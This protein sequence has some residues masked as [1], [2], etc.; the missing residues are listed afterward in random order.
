MWIGKSTAVYFLCSM[1]V[2]RTDSRGQYI[3][4]NSKTGCLKNFWIIFPFN[5]SL[6]WKSSYNKIFKGSKSYEIYKK[7]QVGSDENYKQIKPYL[8]D[9]RFL[10]VINRMGLSLN[11]FLK[12]CK[13]SKKNISTPQYKG[14]R[15]NLEENGKLFISPL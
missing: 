6:L 1:Q 15:R 3:F 7:N 5:Q 2:L 14:Q 4:T 11:K 12:L 10:K 8:H 13:V 9:H